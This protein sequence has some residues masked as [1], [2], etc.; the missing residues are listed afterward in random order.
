MSDIRELIDTETKNLRSLHSAVHAAYEVRGKSEHAMRDWSKACRRFQQYMPLL[1]DWLRQIDIASLS[2]RPDLKDFA[3]T[4]LEMDPMYFGS[5]YIKERLLR[6][7]K[8]ADLNGQ[9]RARLIAVLVDAVQRRG[10]RE[11]RD[12][13]RLAAVLKPPELL[14]ESMRLTASSDGRARSRAQM[15]LKYLEGPK[16]PK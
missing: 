3:I 8:S 6:R 9:E 5:G 13:C 2:D 11:F 10:Q 16:K 15:M 4:F 7:L 1:H 14:E 12:Y